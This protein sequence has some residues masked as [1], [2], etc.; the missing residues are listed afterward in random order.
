MKNKNR[1]RRKNLPTKNIYIKKDY[2]EPFFIMIS[3]ASGTYISV[4][5]L[6]SCISIGND[7]IQRKRKSRKQ[8][9]LL[10]RKARKARNCS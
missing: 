7:F 3:V 1:F 6:V 8:R 4:I 10:S 5:V 2:M 9:G